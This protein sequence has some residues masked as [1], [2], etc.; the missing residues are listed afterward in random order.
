MKTGSRRKT[1]EK[2]YLYLKECHRLA[3]SGVKLDAYRMATQYR[4]SK[5]YFG[6]AIKLQ[7]FNRIK[8]GY[9]STPIME[10][11]TYEANLVVAASN[12][13]QKKLTKVYRNTNK[14]IY[15]TNNSI[16]LYTDKQLFE[17]LKRR[18]YNGSLSKSFEL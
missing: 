18:G 1:I 6:A 14:N 10:F 12:N 7:F 11:T 3:V 13:H 17:E 8:K 5:A 4:V 16:S 15:N 2:A 9:Y